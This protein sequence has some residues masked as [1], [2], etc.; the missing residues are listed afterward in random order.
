[1]KECTCRACGRARELSTSLL[2]FAL[3]L[4]AGLAVG[5]LLIR[6]GV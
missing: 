6:L 5:A 1:M 3:S 2:V 4:S